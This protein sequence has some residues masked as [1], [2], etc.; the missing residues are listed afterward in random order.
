[1]SGRRASARLQ[2]TAGRCDGEALRRLVQHLAQ[3]RHDLVDPRRRQLAPTSAGQVGECPRNVRT[4]AFAIVPSGLALTPAA[5]ANGRCRRR[6]ADAWDATRRHFGAPVSENASKV[7]GIFAGQRQQEPSWLRRSYCA[8]GELCCLRAVRN[9]CRQTKDPCAIPSVTRLSNACTFF[10][11]SDEWQRGP[12][13]ATY[14][15]VVKSEQ[16]AVVRPGTHP[17]MRH[18]AVRHRN[19][20]A[21]CR[22]RVADIALNR[23]R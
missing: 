23:P 16:Q 5:G 19:H 6:P 18:P 12:L 1:M 21:A 17:A 9:V 20:R 11:F 10:R 2:A 3:D 22:R 13:T 14:A 8:C 15:A 4:S 7:G